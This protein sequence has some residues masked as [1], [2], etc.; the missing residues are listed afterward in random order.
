[1]GRNVSIFIFQF[2][3]ELSVFP[4]CIVKKEI[5]KKKTSFSKLFRIAEKS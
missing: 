1:M 3:A 5:K 4:L 2:A